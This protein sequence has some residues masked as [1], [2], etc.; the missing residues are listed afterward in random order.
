MQATS[1]SKLRDES[2]CPVAPT[3]HM[4][5]GIFLQMICVRDGE[6]VRKTIPQ[7]QVFIGR[8]YYYFIDTLIHTVCV[9]KTFYHYNDVIMGAMASQI[10]SLTIVCSA[11]YLGENRLFSP[12]SKKTSKLRV[13]GFC[14]GNSPVTGEF[15]AQRASNA[16]NVSVWWR[17]NALNV[18]GKRNYYWTSSFASSAIV[19]QEI[20]RQEIVRQEIIYDR[21][22]Q[23]TTNWLHN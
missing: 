14:V 2:F 19:R 23:S 15:P 7:K 16:E 18:L 9:G 5:L 22:F 21:I 1:L 20:K 4:R 3:F 11:L 17:H 10:T 6:I 13:T 8:F 12:R